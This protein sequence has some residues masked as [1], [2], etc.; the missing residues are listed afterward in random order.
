MVTTSQLC[1]ISSQAGAS[2]A[3]GTFVAQIEGPA[4]SLP[5]LAPLATPV[6]WGP[7]AVARVV[8]REAVDD[9]PEDQGDLEA[10]G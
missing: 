4:M 9:D 10:A 7:A 2:I 6:Q 5:S 8:A 3:R 1:Q